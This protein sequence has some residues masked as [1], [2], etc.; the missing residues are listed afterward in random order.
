MIVGLWTPSVISGKNKAKFTG[1]FFSSSQ[2]RAGTVWLVTAVTAA[3]R[4][5]ETGILATR[6]YG[7]PGLGKPWM[8]SVPILEMTIIESTYGED[9]KIKRILK[10]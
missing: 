7:L 4:G 6:S 2:S 9:L 10:L 5:I 8:A 3:A 1:S